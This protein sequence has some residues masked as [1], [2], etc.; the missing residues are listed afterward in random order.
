MSARTA[1]TLQRAGRFR[2][3]R[4][5]TRDSGCCVLSLHRFLNFGWWRWLRVGSGGF[6][7]RLDLVLVCCD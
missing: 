3:T 4:L 5:E 1:V 7:A 2:P 6:R